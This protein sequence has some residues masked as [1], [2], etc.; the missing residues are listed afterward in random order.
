MRC[1]RSDSRSRSSNGRRR[2]ARLPS[3]HTP[4]WNDWPPN[5]TSDAVIDVSGDA[6]PARSRH[7]GLRRP[8]RRTSNR[9]LARRA[10]GRRRKCSRSGWPFAPS[11][12]CGRAWPRSIWRR[13]DSTRRRRRGSRPATV[14]ESPPRTSAAAM[15]HVDLQAGAAL[16]TEPRR[17]RARAHADRARRVERCARGSSCRRRWRDSV[18]APRSSRRLAAR[19]SASNTRWS[20]RAPARAPRERCSLTWR[21]SAGVLRTAIDGAGGC[22]R[23]RALRRAVVLPA[24]CERWARG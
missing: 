12:R 6:L 14:A 11:T 2:R 21:S 23:R 24:R 18:A 17:R 3:N 22:A 19:V 9:D 4:G 20:A 13:R 16:L 10:G 1:C 15:G 8:G 5:A 7:L